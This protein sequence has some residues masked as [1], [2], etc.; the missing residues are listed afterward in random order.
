MLIGV[1]STALRFGDQTK[2]WLSFFSTTTIGGLLAAG[3]AAHMP[4]PYFIA[5]TIGTFL[6]PLFIYKKVLVIWHGKFLH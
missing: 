2:Q 5:T 3:V 1:K 6:F 4:L